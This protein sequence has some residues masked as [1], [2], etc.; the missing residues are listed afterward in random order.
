VLRESGN[1]GVRDS[2]CRGEGNVY[3]ADIRVQDDRYRFSYQR[4]PTRS[5]RGRSLLRGATDDEIRMPPRPPSHRALTDHQEPPPTDVRE[6]LTRLRPRFPSSIVRTIKR[7]RSQQAT[8]DAAEASAGPSLRPRSG[9]LSLLRR[10][11]RR[12]DGDRDGEHDDDHMRDDHPPSPPAAPAAAA[13]AA[14]PSV[15][16]DDRLSLAS[17]DSDW[18]AH[19]QAPDDEEESEDND[20][21]FGMHLP[22]PPPLGHPHALPG[23]HRATGSGRDDDRMAV[24]EGEGEGE[25]H[26]G[27]PL[28]ESVSVES[29]N[30]WRPLVV[31]DARAGV[32]TLRVTQDGQFLLVN[33][34]PFEGSQYLRL[35]LLDRLSAV[36]QPKPDLKS[37]MEVHIYHIPTLTKVAVLKG[38]VAFT[39]KA[40]PFLINLM[41]GGP[42]PDLPFPPIHH[43]R[44]THDHPAPKP[45]PSSPPPAA[46]AAAAAAAPSSSARD[47]DAMMDQDEPSD[48]QEPSSSCVEGARR[49]AGV[50]GQQ[51]PPWRCY[52]F[53]A[54][55]SEDHRVYVWHMRHQRLV[56]ILANGHTDVVNSVSWNSGVPGLLASCGDEGHVCLWSPRRLK[57]HIIRHGA[58]ALPWRRNTA[59]L[60]VARREQ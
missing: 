36:R 25:D 11:R 24:D 55:G 22:T 29:T 54:S 49:P 16:D 6:G 43:T 13:A 31:I 33:C 60:P 20:G 58:S 30:D 52:D 41:E 32:L 47:A 3:V 7:R 48:G 42:G 51:Q 8:K 9:V 21:V 18:A 15:C 12:E 50:C 40:C 26:G 59:D 27:G 34:R 46:A 56:S 39:T 17:I 5:L 10:H 1:D 45:T 53:V 2:R 28:V 35:R 38:H 23:P 57:H 19:C 37:A 4:A 44:D 14:R